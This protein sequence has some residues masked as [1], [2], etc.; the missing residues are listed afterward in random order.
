MNRNYLN[1]KIWGGTLTQLSPFYLGYLR[2][3]YCLDALCDTN[4]KIL[5]VGCGGGGFVASV[6]NYRHDL[7]VFAVDVNK[8]AIISGS[9]KYKDIHFKTGNAYALPYRKSYF[10][11]VLIEDV[12]EHLASPQKALV[13][14][15]RVLRE[16]GVFHAYVPLEGEWYTL[17]NLLYKLGWRAKER[18]AGDIQQFSI[19]S[20]RLS[21]KK[22]GF[23]IVNTKYSTH[24]LGQVVDAGYFE[25]LSLLNRKLEVGLEEDLSHKAKIF[26]IIKNVVTAIIN[27]ESIFLS[28]VPSAGVHITAVK[29]E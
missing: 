13:E 5:E 3:K 7:K 25:F 22:A 4:G 27:F 12:L 15:S 18:L 29:S 16:N 24:L 23:K 21:F 17:H 19:F 1:S 9:T 2:L 10:D 8:K 14:I 28:K 11:A 6:K 20:L 26:R